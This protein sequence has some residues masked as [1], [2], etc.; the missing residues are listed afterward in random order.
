MMS[1]L[2]LATVV[3]TV[4]AAVAVSSCTSGSTPQPAS[5]APAASPAAP[6]PAAA[7][8]AS[9]AAGYQPIGGA[10]QGVS[11]DVP[12]T[13]QTV[14]FSQLSL[15][16]A[17]SQ[18]ALPGVS[19]TQ[20]A[21]ELQPLANVHGVMAI[22]TSADVQTH[23]GDFAPTVNAYCTSSGTTQSGGAGVSYLRQSTQS[24]L[25]Q[26]LATVTSQTSTSFGGVAGVENVYN[27]SPAPGVVVFAAQL[28]ALP[29]SGRA[30]YVTLSAPGDLPSL[31]LAEA[32][33]TVQFH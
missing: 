4:A 12:S 22:D 29:A 9:S 19:E 31:A 3:A 17:F 11:V 28:A 27:S 26:E 25:T 30:C 1:R 2:A 15:Q 8:P 6:G 7:S 24:T 13:W 10:A 23:D 20:F 33:S 18:L 32:I 14:D 21:Q 5:S 16:Q